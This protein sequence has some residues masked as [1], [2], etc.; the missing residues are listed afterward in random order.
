M[1]K[2]KRLKMG[3]G[4]EIVIKGIKYRTNNTKKGH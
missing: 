2:K 3:Y 4:N 1:V